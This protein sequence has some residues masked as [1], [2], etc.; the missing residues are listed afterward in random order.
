MKKL[1]P[2]ALGAMTMALSASAHYDDH[3]EK[4]YVYLSPVNIVVGSDASKRDSNKYPDYIYEDPNS[5]RSNPFDYSNLES[6]V[7]DRF[8]ELKKRQIQNAGY[9]YNKNR[10]KYETQIDLARKHLINVNITRKARVNINS[11]NYNFIQSYHINR[12]IFT[13]M[14]MNIPKIQLATPKG[15]FEPFAYDRNGKNNYFGKHPS[16]K[17]LNNSRTG[18]DWED[19]SPWDWEKEWDTPRLGENR[20]ANLKWE[21]DFTPGMIYNG[22]NSRERRNVSLNDNTYIHFA[23]DKFSPNE[24]AGYDDNIRKMFQSTS[25]VFYYDFEVN[26]K[27]N[28]QLDGFKAFRSAE[29][30]IEVDCKEDNAFSLP[31]EIYIIEKA[32]ADSMYLRQDRDYNWAKNS[33]LR[34]K[35][36]GMSPEYCVLAGKDGKRFEGSYDINIFLKVKDSNDRLINNGLPISLKDTKDSNNNTITV[37]YNGEKGANDEQNCFTLDKEDTS[38]YITKKAHFFSYDLFDNSGSPRNI[39]VNAKEFS[40]TPAGY[41]LYFNHLRGEES[42]DKIGTKGSLTFGSELLTYADLV[43]SRSYGLTIK[44]QKIVNNTYQDISGYHSNRVTAS[45]KKAI[46]TGCDLPNE[47]RIISNGKSGQNLVFEGGDA[48][49]PTTINGASRQSGQFGITN[50]YNVIEFNKAGLFEVQIS[51]NSWIYKPSVDQSKYGPI[52]RDRNS[53]NAGEFTYGLIDCDLNRVVPKYINFKPKLEVKFANI[54]NVNNQNF[55]YINDLRK[56]N[57]PLDSNR[58]VTDTHKMVANMRVEVNALGADGN[59]VRNYSDGCITN[60][61]DLKIRYNKGDANKKIIFSGANAI[62]QKVLLEQSGGYDAN[63]VSARYDEVIYKIPNSEFKNGQATFDIGFN[64]ERS[65]SSPLPPFEVTTA[66]FDATEIKV[67]PNNILS[68]NIDT[69]SSRGPGKATMVYGRALLPTYEGGSPISGNVFYTYYCDN[70]ANC[71][72]L[73]AVGFTGK[74]L[75]EPNPRPKSLPSG[76]DGFYINNLH[77]SKTTLGEHE[78][79]ESNKHT[80]V[81]N[82]NFGNNG[83]QPIT[84]KNDRITA[85]DKD[86]IKL[87]MPRSPWL[88]FNETESNDF[89]EGTVEFKK[90]KKALDAD[91]IGMDYNTKGKSSGGPG[92]FIEQN[93][94][95]NYKPSQRIDW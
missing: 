6:Q 89:V 30:K 5:Y 24:H 75:T 68:D 13:K 59:R 32:Y 44:P 86:I 34:P 38:K 52:C 71:D 90:E 56:K 46:K 8:L 39:I 87:Y 49:T 88:I 19:A 11:G 95:L 14:T 58:N 84:L 53:V 93:T 37:N 66:D 48:I 76:S 12:G 60:N 81:T 45:L 94:S 72:M 67:I 82:G 65:N 41:R 33:P 64:F 3:S 25:A 23:I 43:S 78:R 1:L 29:T 79:A 36:S 22:R 54:R 92:K 4:C 27:A 18:N 28:L 47:I 55:T 51:D 10:R 31:D 17:I 16:V 40:I 7:R 62:D 21:V 74:A 80:I 57:I 63:S 15:F 77:N 70:T 85:K 2:I 61:V 42:D 9:D 83:I 26:T 69:Y 91:W 35:I 20:E 50:A 73:R